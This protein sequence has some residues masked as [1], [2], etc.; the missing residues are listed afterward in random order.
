MP[1]P[2]TP[3]HGSTCVWPP[4]HTRCPLLLRLADPSIRSRSNR[5]CVDLVG[6]RQG[7]S[8]SCPLIESH[9][10]PKH[11]FRWNHYHIQSLPTRPYHSSPPVE[12]NPSNRRPQPAASKDKP[13]FSRAAHTR[14]NR[15]LGWGQP[16]GERERLQTPPPADESLVTHRRPPS[17]PDEPA[18]SSRL[19][20]PKAAAAFE[21]GRGTPQRA[22]GT[23]DAGAA[24]ALGACLV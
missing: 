19:R 24:L 22:R 15:G 10:S 21:R 3:P 9:D 11:C 1:K 20:Q 2:T 4:P 14:V 23:G 17:R 6:P 12:P 5:S 7:L 18:R 13:G 8:R 16:K